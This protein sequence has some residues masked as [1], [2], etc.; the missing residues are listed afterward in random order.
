MLRNTNFSTIFK[1][2]KAEQ[3]DINAFRSKGEYNKPPI[4]S[5]PTPHVQTRLGT[6]LQ[7]PHGSSQ[8]P[9]QKQPLQ[10]E[11]PKDV[12]LHTPKTQDTAMHP[13]RVRQSEKLINFVFAIAQRHRG[14]FSQ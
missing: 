8:E 12:P 2:S 6:G 1:N 14:P 4:C 5:F 3:T 10:S 13:L 9:V 11:K 7:K